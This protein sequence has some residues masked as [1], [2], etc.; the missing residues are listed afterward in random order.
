MSV[1]LFKPLDTRVLSAKIDLDPH[2]LIIRYKKPLMKLSDKR[3]RIPTQSVWVLQ[4]GH[5]PIPY[6]K[7]I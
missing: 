5:S 6:Q 7:K 3:S 1:Y 2:I 4:K